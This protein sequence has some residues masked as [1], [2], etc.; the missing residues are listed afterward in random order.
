MDGVGALPWLHLVHVLVVLEEGVPV[1]ARGER[2]LR[3]RSADLLVSIRAQVYV[4]SKR[5]WAS[6]TPPTLSAFS[7]NLSLLDLLMQVNCIDIPCILVPS[8]GRSIYVL[9]LH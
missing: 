1:V 4:T 5:V 6:F 2:R 8:R 9:R 3:L 7:R